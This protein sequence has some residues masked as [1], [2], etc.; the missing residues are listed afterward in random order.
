MYI[1]LP[2]R[3]AEAKIKRLKPAVCYIPNRWGK[4]RSTRS[5]LKLLKLY[6]QS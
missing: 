4:M 3:S 2:S 5:E 6:F 1:S